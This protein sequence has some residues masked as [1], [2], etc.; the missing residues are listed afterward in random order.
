MNRFFVSMHYVDDDSILNT[1]FC[2]FFQPIRMRHGAIF[3]H[4]EVLQPRAF[5]HARFMSIC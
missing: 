1:I 5:H 4:F 3:E 2:F